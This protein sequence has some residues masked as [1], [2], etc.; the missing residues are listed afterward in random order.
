MA[1][2]R[3]NLRI[4]I[5]SDSFAPV[6]NGVSVSIEGLIEELRAMG[7]SVHVFTSSYPNY[8]EK[9]PNV[10]RFRSIMTRFAKSYPLAI[11]PFSPF[12]KE[13]R[14]LRFD[15]VHTHTPFTVGLIGKNWA[16][17]S[18]IPLVSTYH[19]L[20]EEYAHYVPFLPKRF[21]QF[22]IAR[23]TNRYYNQCAHIIVPSEIAKENLLEH[24]VRQ[25]ITII[26]T[27]NPAPRKRSREDARTEIGAKPETKLL[28]YV[29]RLAREKNLVLLFRALKIVLSKRRDIQLW[30][31][32]DGPDA[33]NCKRKV[34]LSGIG[35]YVVFTGAVPRSK[36]DGYYAAADVFVFPS[37]TE[38]QGLVIGEA[39]SYGLPVVV[40]RGGGASIMLEHGETGFVVDNEPQDFA[41]SVLAL[42]SIPALWGRISTN[43]RRFSRQWTFR[44]MAQSVLEVY[45]QVLSTPKTI[46]PP[47]PRK[48][49]ESILHAHTDTRKN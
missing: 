26:P 38:T 41:N 49:P 17:Q 45:E 40:V 1:D 19:T 28:L 9:D 16:R 36:V 13:F 4:A 25:P 11:P 14:R 33:E 27:G 5:F 37:T 34:R 43:A 2:I 31:V 44:D 21:V 22:L 29:G 39:L 35:D 20:Y 10:I 32:G 18:R 48:E 12:K 30:L 8:M 46:S 23:N 7:H 3:S 6:I 15:I 24:R 42:L 47:L